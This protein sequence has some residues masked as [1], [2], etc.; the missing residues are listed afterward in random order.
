MLRPSAIHLS[1]LYLLLPL[2]CIAGERPSGL[3]TFQTEGAGQRTPRNNGGE[4]LLGK[5]ITAELGKARLFSVSNDNSRFILEL[6]GVGPVGKADTSRLAVVVDD[7]CA[8]IHSRS[9]PDPAGRIDVACHVVTEKAAAK[10]ARHL[11]IDVGLRKHPGHRF[12]TRW[13]SEKP[14][15]PLGGPVLVRMEIRNTGEKTFSFRDGGMQRGARN[16]QFRFLA[17][18]SLGG[19]KAVP[20]SGDPDHFGGK[21]SP[22][23]LKPGE[24]FSK[25]ID[26]TD[27]FAFPREDTYRITGIFEMEV[28][29]TSD[30][31]PF[32]RSVWDDLAVGD[33]LVRMANAR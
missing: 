25:S 10:I 11:K 1:A 20:D 12:E 31:H 3:Y 5:R 33:C 29:E 2:T 8:V 22:V 13:T 17:Y 16:N 6:K 27:W 4:I 18:H 30:E 28:E 21:S 26:L 24:T 14:S 9:D 32:G 7:L 15:F 23:T 19:G